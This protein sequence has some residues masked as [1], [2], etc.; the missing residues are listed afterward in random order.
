MDCAPRIP[1]REGRNEGRNST[2][3][4]GV[5]VTGKVALRG[6]KAWHNGNDE[7]STCVRKTIPEKKPENRYERGEIVRVRDIGFESGKKKGRISHREPRA[8]GGE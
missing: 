4:F 8:P 2:S 7:Q 3:I 1:S 6:G 5:G